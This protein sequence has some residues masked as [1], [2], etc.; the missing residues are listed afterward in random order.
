MSAIYL[1]TYNV[2]VDKVTGQSTRARRT[3]TYT[4]IEKLLTV[5]EYDRYND[6]SICDKSYRKY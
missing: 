1:G 5:L 6:K 3:F 4:H 2:S